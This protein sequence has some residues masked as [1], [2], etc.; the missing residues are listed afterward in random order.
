[1]RPELIKDSWSKLSTQVGDG[2]NENNNLPLSQWKNKMELG[3]EKEI[4]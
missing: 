3:L 4:K 2:W 1:M